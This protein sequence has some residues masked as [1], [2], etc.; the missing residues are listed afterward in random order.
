MTDI[1]RA[2]GLQFPKGTTAKPDRETRRRAF[3]ARDRKGSRQARARAGGRCEA[4]VSGQ[5]CPWQG[6]HV[7]HM[8]GG[9]GK[10]GLEISALAERKQL[11][12]L[13]HH[14]LI[15]QNKLERL[16]GTIP[17]YTDTYRMKER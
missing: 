3:V 12:C 17:H 9:I 10:R 15:H 8:I 1:H 6:R 11:V 13:A 16:G 2:T 5:R 4:I 14:R 7:H